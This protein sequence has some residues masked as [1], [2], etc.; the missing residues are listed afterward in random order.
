MTKEEKIERVKKMIPKMWTESAT[1]NLKK[2]LEKL[3]GNK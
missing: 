2:Y 3:E 1:N